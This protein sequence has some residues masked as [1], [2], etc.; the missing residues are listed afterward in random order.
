MVNFGGLATV[1]ERYRERLL[2]VHNEHVTLMRTT[3][4]ECRAIGTWI[5]QKLNRCEGPVRF[6]I[7]EGGVSA[8]DAPGG[9]FHDPEADAALF[10]ALERTFEPGP[11]RALTRLSYHVNDPEFAAALVSAFRE[12]S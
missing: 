2:H 9:P 5:A 4:D 6:L 11:N 1:P 12:I 3:P 7:P 8:I 10:D